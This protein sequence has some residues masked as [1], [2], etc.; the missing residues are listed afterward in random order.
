MWFITQHAMS[1][2]IDCRSWPKK[3]FSDKEFVIIWCKGGTTDE[4]KKW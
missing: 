3:T 4:Y 2:D 1:V